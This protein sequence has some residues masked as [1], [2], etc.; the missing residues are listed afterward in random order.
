M[1]LLAAAL[2]LSTSALAQVPKEQLA[3]PP[4]D[5]RH[6]VILSTG[7]K[8]GDSYMWTAPDGTRMGRE[9]L[10][11]RG[12]VWETDVS[13]RAGADGMPAKLEVRGVSPNGNVAET[14][15]IASG[16]ASWKSQVDQGSAAYASPAFYSAMGGPMAVNAWFVERLLASPNLTM[17]LLPGGTAS[18]EKLT[19]VSVGE[20]AKK[21]D[22][23]LWAISGVSNAPLPIW[24]DA[25]NRFFGVT[26]I[27]G[28]LPE[29]YE[30]EMP[31][32]EAAQSAAMSAR[33]PAL[34]KS[35]VTVPTTPV[36]LPTP[37]GSCPGRP[38]WST[39]TRSWQSG[40]PPRRVPR[41]ALA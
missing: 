36:A 7:G 32:L 20:G 11:L 13:G 18:A 21:Q 14:F 15:D 33:M 4:A 9:S 6:F 40:P 28:W 16:K 37:S 34:A 8:H 26:F 23:T 19:T 27:L 29:G 31:K 35:L 1:R 2:L 39:R 22:V 3:K 12:Q 25:Q 24:T 41:R 17:K 30:G 10:L 5:A 38:W